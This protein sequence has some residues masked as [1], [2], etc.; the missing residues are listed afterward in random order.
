MPYP[1]VSLQTDRMREKEVYQILN[2]LKEIGPVTTARMKNALGE[3]FVRLFE[4]PDRE[5]LAIKGVGPAVL[6][7]LRHWRDQFDLE[8]EAI[9]MEKYGVRFIDQND[10]DYPAALRQLPDAPLGLY[11]KGRLLQEAPTVAIIGTRDSSGY[12]NR[13]ARELAM[14]LSRNGVMVISGLARGIDTAAHWGAVDADGAT[15]AV[16]GH[17]IEQVYPHENRE[18]RDR[19][20][21]DGA[22]V[23]EFPLGRRPDR[24]TFPMRNRLVSGLA[25]AVVVVETDI[26]GGSMITAGFAADQGKTVFAVPGNLH[27]KNSRGCHA[28]IRDGAILLS[29]VQDVLEDIGCIGGF[30]LP[31]SSTIGISGAAVSPGGKQNMSRKPLPPGDSAELLG[32]WRPGNRMTLDCW[33]KQNGWP[34]SRLQAALLILE[35][36]GYVRKAAD[37]YYERI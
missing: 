34:I 25:D 37:G 28:L 20:L 5:L 18:L 3:R 1:Y 36:Q 2:A 29:S 23:S 35:L 31:D 8:R 33:V 15:L 13:V 16:L 4:L 7:S 11:W 24:Q 21:E 17:G 19:I 27:E 12:G 9:R 14:E 26:R 10:E 32:Q 30:H 6:H 22:V